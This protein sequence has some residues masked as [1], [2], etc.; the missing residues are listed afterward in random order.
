M[1]ELYTWSTPNGRKVSIA[2]EE[3]KLPYTVHPVNIRVDEQFSAE[4]LRL[5]PNN[6]IPAILDTDNDTSVFETGAIL[7]YLAEKSGMFLPENHP[8]RAKVQEWLAWQIAGFGPMLGQLNHFANN[9]DEQLPYAIKRFADESI[10]LFSVLDKQL[11]DNEFVAGD[12]S[13]ADM[14]IYPWSIAAYSGVTNLA[15]REFESVANWHQKMSD[16]PGVKAGMNVKMD[17]DA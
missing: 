9:A 16:R 3:M 2:L 12:Y 1:I 4:F 14:A 15:G 13:I 6:K 7:T 11:S 8:G 10:R 5:G 17:S